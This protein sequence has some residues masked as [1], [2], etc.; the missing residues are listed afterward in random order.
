MTTKPNFQLGASN[1]NVSWI[2]LKSFIS[3]NDRGGDEN[4]GD[5]NPHLVLNNNNNNLQ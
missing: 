3:D 2:Q 4:E 1:N 5:N